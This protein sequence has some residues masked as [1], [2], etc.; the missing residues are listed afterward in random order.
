MLRHHSACF[1]INLPITSIIYVSMYI[2][3]VQYKLAQPSP[4]LSTL[5]CMENSPVQCSVTQRT[6]QV[7][8]NSVQLSSIQHTAAV[9]HCY[10]AE[11]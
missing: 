11:I 4:A 2:N 10:I 8:F 3:A 6:V 5:F 7:Q 9:A 1:A